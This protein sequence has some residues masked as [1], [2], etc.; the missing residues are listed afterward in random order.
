M[1]TCDLTKLWESVENSSDSFHEKAMDGDI[2][3]GVRGTG[4]TV[5][6]FVLLMFFVCAF[7]RFYMPLLLCSVHSL[8]LAL[9]R[10]SYIAF[11]QPS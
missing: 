3:P 2:E 1:A 8:Q 11:R 5:C 10:E 9:V 4:S 7:L 6:T